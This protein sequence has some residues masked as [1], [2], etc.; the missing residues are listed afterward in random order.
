MEFII[1]VSLFHSGKFSL[2]HSLIS[3]LAREINWLNEL[4]KLKPEL[5]LVYLPIVVNQAMQP[6]FHSDFLSWIKPNQIK[7]KTFSL[8]VG[9]NSEIRNEMGC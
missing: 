5:E 3:V 8:F 7:L 1:T 4:T 9:L 6:Q 2:I